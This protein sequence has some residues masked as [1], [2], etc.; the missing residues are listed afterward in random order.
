MTADLP[1]L[2]AEDQ[3]V[4]DALWTVGGTE[5]RV[6]TSEPQPQPTT[7]AP[8]TADAHQIGTMARAEAEA[9]DGL[10]RLLYTH[11]PTLGGLFSTAIDVLAAQ[12][13]PITPGQA[14]TGRTGSVAQAEAKLADLAGVPVSAVRARVDDTLRRTGHDN[15]PGH[16][17]ALVALAAARC[18]HPMEHDEALPALADGLLGT[19]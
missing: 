2:T 17:E 3:A 6:I 13:S 10:A 11:P 7:E 5:S 9:R 19:R 4:Y 14:A 18:L 16:R 1:E 15:V 12:G 8:V